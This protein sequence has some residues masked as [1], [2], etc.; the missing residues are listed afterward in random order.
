S[1]SHEQLAAFDHRIPARLPLSPRTVASMLNRGAF[2]S[3]LGIRAFY[4]SFPCIAYLW[5]PWPMLATSA[6]LVV[7]LFVVDLHVS[8]DE[9]D[10]GADE[11]ATRSAAVAASTASFGIA[12]AHRPV[13]RGGNPLDAASAVIG[14]EASGYIGWPVRYIACAARAMR[15]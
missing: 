15:R 5:G 2:F 10:G 6:F 8:P 13:S 3:T 11:S 12:D 7:L 1:A 14:L 4:V 9:F